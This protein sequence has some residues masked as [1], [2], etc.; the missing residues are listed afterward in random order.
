MMFFIAKS[1]L[2]HQITLYDSLISHVVKLFNL[3]K[4]F[5]Y[6]NIFSKATEGK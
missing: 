3:K 4:R 2:F 5:I 6:L 1:N